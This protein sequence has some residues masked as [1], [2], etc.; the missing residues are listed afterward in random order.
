MT[1]TAQLQLYDPVIMRISTGFLNQTEL[2]QS[3]SIYKTAG[4][5]RSRA[6]DDYITALQ[7]PL[8]AG[9]QSSSATVGSK[10]NTLE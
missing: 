10:S 8:V 9:G 3:A 7:R 6:A 4:L 1:R 5:R 2:N